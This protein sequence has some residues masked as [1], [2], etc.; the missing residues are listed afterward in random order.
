MSSSDKFLWINLSEELI[1]VLIIISRLRIISS[2]TETTVQHNTVENTEHSYSLTIVSASGCIVCI[3]QYDNKLFCFL[4][5]SNIKNTINVECFLLSSQSRLKSHPC[6]FCPVYV[7]GVLP[8]WWWWWWWLLPKLRLSAATYYRGGCSPAP[9][10]P[11]ETQLMNCSPLNCAEPR[12]ASPIDGRASNEGSRNSVSRRENWD[13]SIKIIRKWH[14]GWLALSAGKVPNRC[15]L[16]ECENFAK[17]RLKL[18]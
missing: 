1:I 4:L 3:R 7:L 10:A 6:E 9:W 5:L 15:L 17:L 14:M 12:P 18:W 2:S 16:R 8:G 11:A 13:A